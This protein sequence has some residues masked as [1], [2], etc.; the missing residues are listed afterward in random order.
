MRYAEKLVY[1]S[2]K[3]KGPIPYH[4][5]AHFKIL[6]VEQSDKT[7]NASTKVRFITVSYQG[8]GTR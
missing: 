3:V 4:S 8:E 2:F 6:A 7:L 1:T 5:V